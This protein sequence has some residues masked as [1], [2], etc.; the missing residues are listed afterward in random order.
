MT[1][2]DKTGTSPDAH[3]RTAAKHGSIYASSRH[4]SPSLSI[5]CLFLFSSLSLTLSLCLCLSPRELEGGG[6]TFDRNGSTG[7]RTRLPHGAGRADLTIV[8]N[9]ASTGRSRD[10]PPFTFHFDLIQTQFRRT[11][12]NAPPLCTLRVN[13]RDSARREKLFP[14]LLFSC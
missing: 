1:D 5:S 6:V 11:H 7:I 14:S 13:T 2:R 12:R 10:R 4:A 9:R 3:T 8:G